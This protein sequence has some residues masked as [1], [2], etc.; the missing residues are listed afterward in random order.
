MVITCNNGDIQCDSYDEYEKHLKEAILNTPGNEIWCSCN[1]GSDDYPCIAILTKDT[2]AVVNY[3]SEQNGGIYA[4]IGDMSKNGTAEFE[5][6][7]YSA[8]EYQIIPA[9][10][11]LE[12]ALQFYH[13]Q[14]RPSCIKWEEL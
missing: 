8:A 11:A 4:S 7:Q 9:D 3:F 5:N 6:G 2:S 10:M 13:S 14:K 12:C 1:G